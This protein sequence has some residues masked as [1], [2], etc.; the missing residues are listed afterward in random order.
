MRRAFVQSWIAAACGLVLA[1]LASGQ[2]WE[3]LGP[4]PLSWFGG[5]A[6][7]I[8]AV[9][10]SPTDPGLYYV[11]GA[12]GGV[13]R[14]PNGGETWEPITGRMPTSSI[15]AIA[16][17]PTDEQT[18]YVGTGESNYANHSRYGLGVFK[19]TDGGDTWEHLAEEVFGGRCFSKIQVNHQNPQIL[20]A[21]ITR[22]GGFPELAAAKNH[23]GATGLLGV[24]RSDDGGHSWVHLEGGLPNVS[25]TDLTID[26]VNP[27]VLY[28]GIGRIF[29]A[30]ENGVYKTMDGGLS[31]TKLT[32][33]LPSTVGRVSV[34]VAPSDPSRLFALLANPC[35][36]TGGGASNI[37]GFR[38]DDAGA[39]WVSH[40]GV[41]QASYG[42]YLSV[43][44]VKPDD[45]NT[46]FYGGLQMSRYI[47]GSGAT[48]TPPHVDQH[49]LAWDAAGRLVAGDDGGVHVSSNLGNSWTNLNA[50][51]GTVQFYAG[52]SSHPT[53]QYFLFGGTQDNG[54]NRRFDDSR[55][56]TTAV[57][58]DGG[59]TQLDRTRPQIV[60]AESQGTG[61]LYKSTN[62]GV[63]FGSS[64]SGLSGRNAFLPP[65]V[66]DPNEPD[67]ML[68]GSHRV[69]ESV[70]G[71]GFWSPIS[72]D[73]TD[74]N[75][76][77]IRALAIA[78]SD[79]SVVYAATNNSR[80]LR[81][82]DGGQSFTL[83]LDDNLGW[84][85]VTRELRV[86][87]RDAMT[88]YL[89]GAVFGVDQV[90]RSTDG[91]QT[92]QS[93]D[94]DLPDIPVN[95]IGLDTRCATTVLYAGTD[96]GIYR[97]VD[98][99]QSWR[100]YGYGI[101]TAVI[102]DLLF[103]PDRE[104]LF[105]GTQGRGAWQVALLIPGDIDGSGNVNTLDLLA[106]LNAFNNRDESADLNGDGN[107][108]TLDFLV[109]LNEFNIGCG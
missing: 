50:G 25:A 28:A 95:V 24:F 36:P 23:P 62:G 85:R 63:S 94:G 109:M 67:R 2:Q 103:E 65:Y 78:P 84:P 61:G 49:A 30:P 41:S 51:L 20:Y 14:T 71:G 1:G 39:T 81:S 87:P 57:G 83:L 74:S 56:W 101:S 17:D 70:N 102:I 107:V 86:D 55:Q 72:G 35:S 53:D 12:D 92:W 76:A 31:W 52:L 58:G 44:S 15:G 34:Q 108:D 99:G 33:G 59:W 100:P 106:Y 96:A 18:I 73:L 19:S 105:A 13:W 54:S 80:V 98:D 93:L 27:N 60:F 82:D 5:S 104:T 21:S 38:S 91:G 40:G 42:W 8:A 77:A 22:A 48:V 11:G 37:G 4:A 69:Y 3:E 7:R 10:C 43:V 46:V 97:S 6:G 68:Y 88:V 66:I 16:L 32:N 26:P 90:R 47:N 29:G 64:G 79:S 45:P 89:A 9:A 75:W